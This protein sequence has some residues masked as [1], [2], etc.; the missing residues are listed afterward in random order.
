MRRTRKNPRA[1]KLSGI[2]EELSNLNT[3]DYKVLAL[4]IGL[5]A[6]FMYVMLWGTR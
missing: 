2:F 6:F 3:Y 5:L 4:L 1:G